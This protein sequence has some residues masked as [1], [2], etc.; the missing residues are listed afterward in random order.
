MN[1]RITEHNYIE[2][3]IKTVMCYRVVNC[4][5]EGPSMEIRFVRRTMEQAT[6]VSTDLNERLILR[7]N[8][9]EFHYDE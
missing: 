2:M 5:L 6:T 3:F 1:L 8:V 9:A 4:C 7:L